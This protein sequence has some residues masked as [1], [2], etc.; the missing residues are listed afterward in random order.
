MATNLKLATVPEPGQK[1]ATARLL[2][3][4]QAA[5]MLGVPE[6]TLSQWRSQRRGPPFVKLG[7]LVRYRALDL[8]RYI[9][10][11]VVETVEK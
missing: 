8:D 11:C 2:T 6:G 9:A 1:F 7:R 5:E 3:P 4:T 10:G